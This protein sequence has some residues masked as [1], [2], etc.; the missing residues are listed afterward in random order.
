MEH[1]P[2]AVGE[3]LLEPLTTAP[4]LRWHPF[5]VPATSSYVPAYSELEDKMDDKRKLAEV[6]EKNGGAILNGVRGSPAT[7]ILC[8]GASV[9]W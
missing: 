3:S 7:I 4:H 8:Q 2:L 1:L 6:V 5:F 9:A